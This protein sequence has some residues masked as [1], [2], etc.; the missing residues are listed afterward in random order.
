MRRTGLQRV[1]LCADDALISDYTAHNMHTVIANALTHEQDEGV[2]EALYACIKQL[3]QTVS[4]RAWLKQH[5]LQHAVQAVA[6]Q[7]AN[8]QLQLAAVDCL[9]AM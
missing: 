4:R 2:R 1:A 6:E 5:R 7:E 9:S 8:A 3:A